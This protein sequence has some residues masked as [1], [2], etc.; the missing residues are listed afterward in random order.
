MIGH[1]LP[2]KL[3]IFSFKQYGR[4]C[5]SPLYQKDESKNTLRN[6]TT[7]RTKLKKVS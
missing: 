4:N 5:F 1:I 2:P 7:V 6:N 3:L